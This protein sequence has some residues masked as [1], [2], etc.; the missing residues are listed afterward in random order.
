MRLEVTM[1]QSFRD[2]HMPFFYA[3]V[4]GALWEL[5]E[6]ITSGNVSLQIMH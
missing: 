4:L 6:V 1:E 2:K 3:Y 5:E